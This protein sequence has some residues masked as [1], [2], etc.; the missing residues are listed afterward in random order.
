MHRADGRPEFFSH[1]AGGLLVDPLAFA[2]GK[3][4]QGRRDPA[5][6]LQKINSV[7]FLPVHPRERLQPGLHQCLEEVFDAPDVGRYL[8]QV[9]KNVLLG[10]VLQQIVVDVVVDKERFVALRAVQSEDFMTADWFDF[11]P[12]VLRKISSRITNEVEGINRVTYD[13][14]SKPPAV[15]R[16]V[17]TCCILC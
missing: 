5:Q 6:F 15:C 4:L 10:V 8:A 17:I 2:H 13:I 12:S 7:L 1:L 3:L 9:R 16:D 14:S 11:P